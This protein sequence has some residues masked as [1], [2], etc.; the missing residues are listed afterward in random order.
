MPPSPGSRNKLIR[1]EHKVG[2][3]LPVCYLLHDVF[4]LGLFLDPEDGGDISFETLFDSKRLHDI[5]SQN[6]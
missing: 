1:N 6:K 4:L 2:S 5:I 3:K